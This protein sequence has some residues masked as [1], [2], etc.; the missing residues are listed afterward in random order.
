MSIISTRLNSIKPSPTLAVVKKT[1]ELKKAGVDIIALGAGEPDF[2]TPDNIKEAAIKAIKDGYT[3][4][5]NVEGMPLLKQAIKDKFKRENNIDY[6]LDEIIVSTGGKQVIYNLFMASLDK[7]DEV[8]IPAPYW[9]SYPDMVALSTGT[10]VFVNCG[11]ENN[12]KLSAEA[13]ERLIN[14]K[15]KWLIINSPSNPTGASYNF[16]ELENIAKVL[17]KYPHVNVMSDDIYE[18]ITLMILN[19]IH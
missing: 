2:D 12:F 3:K 1:L 10:P 7:G 6:E 18:H 19:F 5:T 14:D 17:R 4:Y 16:E 13:L 11:I 8:I 15:T 9:V